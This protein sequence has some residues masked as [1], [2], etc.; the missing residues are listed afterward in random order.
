MKGGE[1]ERFNPLSGALYERSETHD[2]NEQDEVQST[3]STKQTTRETYQPRRGRQKFFKKEERSKWKGKGRGESPY[4]KNLTETSSK[5][6]EVSKT[7]EK[8]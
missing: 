2:A 4:Q 8:S 1:R 7:K 6:E 3:S 5:T